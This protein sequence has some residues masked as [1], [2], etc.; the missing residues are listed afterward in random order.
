MQ[1][2]LKKQNQG[3]W[4]GKQQVLLKWKKKKDTAIPNDSTKWIRSD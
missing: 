4:E 2:N 3:I 1:N